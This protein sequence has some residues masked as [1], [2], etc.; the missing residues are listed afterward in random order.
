MKTETGRAC[1]TNESIFSA[2]GNTWRFLLK[3]GEAVLTEMHAAK[4]VL[5]SGDNELVSVGGFKGGVTMIGVNGFFSS[6]TLDRERY[7]F[8]SISALRGAEVALLGKYVTI[9]L[10]FETA[11]AYRSFKLGEYDNFCAEPLQMTINLAAYKQVCLKK[12]KIIYD[13]HFSQPPILPDTAGSDWLVTAEGMSQLD[14]DH[15]VARTYGFQFGAGFFVEIG[16]DDGV[17]NS[18]SWMLE[19]LFGWGGIIVEANPSLCRKISE[20][21]NVPCV[22][23]A[24]SSKNGE[25]LEFVDA[26]PLGGLVDFLQS[27]IHQTTRQQAIEQ[28]QVIKVDGVSGGSCFERNSVPKLIHYLSVDTE[29]SEVDVLRSIDFNEWK[30]CLISVEHAG[31]EDK[32]KEVMSYLESFGYQRRRIW[33]EDWFYNPQYLGEALGLSPEEAINHMEYVFFFDPVE[34]ANR[35]S[36]QARECV[37]QGDVV[38]AEWLYHELTKDYYPNNI[39]SFLHYALLFKRKGE[40]ESSMEVLNCARKKA[41]NHPQLLKDL[42][43][44]QLECGLHVEAKQT[45]AH[46]KSVHP[47]IDITTSIA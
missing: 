7:G 8:A 3:K 30:A 31:Q 43:A 41:P 27:D 2:R 16:G 4:I 24:I 34:Q 1:S 25:A 39:A 38:K 9:S 11:R 37:V 23:A 12:E 29:G 22:N 5:S 18:N 32:R 33:F 35:L 40:L 46:A 36:A 45:A 17:Y 28:G 13:D 26:G 44:L 10:M 20:V 14:Q 19:Q 42:I 6:V 15:W 47:D 21:R